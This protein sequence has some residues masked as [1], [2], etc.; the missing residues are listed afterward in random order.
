MNAYMYVFDTLAD[1]EWGYITAEFSSGRYFKKRGSN[2]PFKLVSNSE[3]AVR[4]MGGVSI[5]PDVALSNA[6]IT[7][8]DLL[9]LPGGD[10]WNDPC[11]EP[12]LSLVEK[13]LPKGLTVAAICGATAALAQKGLLNSRKHTSNALEFLEQ[14]CPGYKGSA[15]YVNVPAVADGYLITASGTAPLEFAYQVIK[16]TGVFKPETLESWYNLHHHKEAKYF[17]ELMKTLE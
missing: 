8:D 1:W 16:K 2:L 7:P 14:T 3:K 5:L 12:I 10:T 13:L 11:H 4:T 15:M 6:D 17:H 9:L